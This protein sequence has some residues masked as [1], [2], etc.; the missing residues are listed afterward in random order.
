M[1][2]NVDIRWC[3]HRRFLHPNSDLVFSKCDHD[4]FSVLLVC[5]P[6]PCSKSESALL[7]FGFRGFSSQVGIGVDPMR[8]V[9]TVRVTTVGLQSALIGL[10]CRSLV[11]YC[12]SPLEVKNTA[13]VESVINA[14]P[15][16]RKTVTASWSRRWLP[17]GRPASA[18]QPADHRPQQILPLPPCASAGGRSLGRKS[19]SF[20]DFS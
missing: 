15:P 7:I 9:A 6:N 4:W 19:C 10:L 3:T 1:F 8:G 20:F 14:S 16:W 2:S 13:S 12:P 17:E 5:N 11:Y 18:E